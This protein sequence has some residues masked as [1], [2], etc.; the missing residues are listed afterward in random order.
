MSPGLVVMNAPTASVIAPAR[1]RRRV[2]DLIE[3]CF[4][5]RRADTQRPGPTGQRR[6]SSIAFCTMLTTTARN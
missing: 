6:E 4:A 2:F 1:Y 3:H 5:C